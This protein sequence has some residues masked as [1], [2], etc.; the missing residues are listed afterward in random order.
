MKKL[1]L[2]FT[3]AVLLFGCGQQQSSHKVAAD[4]YYFEKETFVRTDVQVKVVFV[5]DQAEMSKLL[6]EHG[7]SAANG[8]VVAAFSTL[9]L[10]ENACTIY[11]LDPRVSYQ[12]EFIGHEFTHCV[13]GN[14]HTVQP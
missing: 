1:L 14:W 2:A 9:S 3:T 8:N 11:M 10:T 6:V 12:P 4:G 13:F 7:R 5:K